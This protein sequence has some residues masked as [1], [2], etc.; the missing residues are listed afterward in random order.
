MALQQDVFVDIS[1]AFD[2][3]WPE[4]LLFKLKQNGILGNVLM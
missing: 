1:K 2:K 4:S 3:V